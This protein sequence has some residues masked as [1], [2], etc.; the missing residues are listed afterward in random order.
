MLV[1]L[2]RGIVVL[3]SATILVV[4]HIVADESVWKRAVVGHA[5]GERVSH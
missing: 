4:A 5:I 2:R 3:D 1:L